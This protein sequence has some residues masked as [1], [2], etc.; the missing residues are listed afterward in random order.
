MKSMIS[1]KNLRKSFGQH[2]VL[3][4]VSF[5]VAPGEIFCLLGSNGAGKTTAVNILATLGKPNGQGGGGSASINGYDVV[6]Q[7]A[8][9]R[10]SISLTGQYAA[11]DEILTGRDNLHIIAG[12]RRLPNPKEEAS[13]LLEVFRL[14]DAADKPVADYSGGMRRRLDIAMSLMGNSPVIFLDEPTTGLDPQN[15][16]AMWELIREM[17]RN[18]TTVFLTTQYLEEAEQLADKVAILHEGIIIAQGSPKELREDMYCE[19]TQ[20]LPTLEDVFLTHIG[21]K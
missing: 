19:A 6:K 21:E 7:P 16:I 10:A 5:E 17:A 14:T 2:E 20:N 18:G 11:T 9:V 4:G 3:K 8:Y 1:A 12:L 15:R 13:R